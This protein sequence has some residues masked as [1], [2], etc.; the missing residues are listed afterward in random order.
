MKA[1]RTEA[2]GEGLNG[3]A[4]DFSG[5]VM[6]PHTLFALP[7]ALTAVVLAS[8]S[9][10]VTWLK[11]LLIVTAFTGARSAA[12]A[13]NRLIDQ[14]VDSANPRTRGRHLPAGRLSRWQVW[15]F[16]A[17]AVGV[18]EVSAALLG[19]LCLALSPI[20]LAVIFAYSWTKYFT[21][22]SHLVLGLALSIAPVG[23]FIAV[24]GTLTFGVLM[25]ALAV[26]LW[27]AGFDIIYSLQD[28][29]FDREQGLFSV[30]ARLGAARALWLSRA[31]HLLSFAALGAVGSY[32]PVG[33]LY[34]VGVTLIGAMLAFEHSLVSPDDLSR[35]N[36][37]FFT[38]NGAVSIIFLGLNLA[39]RLL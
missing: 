18:F 16:V 25:L 5:L 31:L 33:I 2:S 15:L 20:A 32:F 34:W 17:A 29:A 13:F 11:V 21:A 28:E 35:V 7:F 26:V 10:D 37:A 38:V 4:A 6:L 1:E 3:L 30:P 39:D 8:Y 27:V 24:T 12:M 9:A 14:R 36:A 19:K 23:A 22:A